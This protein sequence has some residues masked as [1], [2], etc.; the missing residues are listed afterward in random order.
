MVYCNC[1]DPFES[2]F[3]KYFAAN[4]NRLGLKKLISTSYNGSHIAGLQLT[5]EEYARGKKGALKP[6]AIALEIDEVTDLDGDGAAI[7]SRTLCGG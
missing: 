6:S 4:F 1:D 5:L 2:N 7:E 3:F